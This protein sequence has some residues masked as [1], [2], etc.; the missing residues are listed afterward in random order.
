MPPNA[1]QGLMAFPG[2]NSV[3]SGSYTIQHGTSPGVAT[4]V[5]APQQNINVLSGPLTITFGPTTITIPNCVVDRASLVLDGERRIV[6]VSIL[7]FRWKWRYG[8]ISGSYNVTRKD[9][10][11]QAN[12]V[13][14]P[15]QLAT[16]CLRA[17]ESLISTWSECQTS[18]G[19]QSNGI[20]P[21]QLKP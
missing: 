15:Q 16:L 20:T 3:Q 4:L 6:Q 5:I 14:S 1:P 7:D 17:M 12:T 21:I 11:L 13:Q 9:G 18:R 2:I 8:D 10:S 19:L